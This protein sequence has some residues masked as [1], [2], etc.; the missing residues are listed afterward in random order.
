V[1]AARFLLERCSPNFC[2]VVHC[3]EAYAG[4]LDIDLGNLTAW[5][6]SPL[7]AAAFAQPGPSR[8]A[9]CAETARAITQSLVNALFA[10]PAQPVT[11]G[12]LAELPAPT[13][14]L[15]R[16]H[17]LPK[18]KP[19]TKWQKFAQQKGITKRKRSKL[20]FDETSQTWKRRHGYGKANDE[21][22]VP[23]IEARAS[24][25]VGQDKYSTG[26]TARAGMAVDLQPQHLLMPHVRSIAVVHRPGCRGR[27]CAWKCC[28]CWGMPGCGSSSSRSLDN[29]P[30]PADI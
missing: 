29:Q 3:R 30:A 26:T 6:P 10:L 23:I 13:T 24:D 12:R 1:T 7:D 20:V 18:P 28:H 4:A 9:A 17:P 2:D 8:E 19:L 5:D 11:G 21:A 27:A 14:R 25:K 16:Q 15:P 22:A